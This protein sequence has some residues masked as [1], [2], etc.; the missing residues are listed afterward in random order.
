MSRKKIDTTK[1]QIEED[2]LEEQSSLDV[3]VEHQKKAADSARKAFLSLIPKGVKEHGKHAVQEM[4]E[5][6]RELFNDVI[7][8]VLDRVKTTKEDINEL[9]DKVG[10]KQETEPV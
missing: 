2:V 1:K 4:L 10:S 7:D 9:V 3:F 8:D 5:G 6:Y